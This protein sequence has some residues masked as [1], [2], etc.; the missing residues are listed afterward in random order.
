MSGK[1]LKRV[2]RVGQSRKELK[3]SGKELKKKVEKSGK[4]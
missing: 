3:I 4:E 1:E 2:K